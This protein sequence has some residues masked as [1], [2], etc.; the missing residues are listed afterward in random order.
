MVFGFIYGD[1]MYNKEF[2][3]RVYSG[4]V[5]PWLQDDFARFMIDSVRDYL[6][7]EK[8]IMLDYGCGNGAVAAY[9]R[10]S[11]A[12]VDTAEIADDMVALLRSTYSGTNVYSVNTPSDIP[13]KYYYDNV[14]CLNVFHHISPEY[15]DVFLD[16][17]HTLIKPGGRLIISG[18]DDSDYY[19]NQN[20]NV[21]LATQ[22]TS[23][24]ITSLVR[25]FVLSQWS[26]IDNTVRKFKYAGFEERSM[27]FY[28][29]VAK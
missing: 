28:C 18:W 26:L 9:F 6:K 1:G 17:L 22:C 11:G 5:K 21:A 24:T 29:L 20:D 23:W 27:R 7:P 10:N 2:W 15:W 16:Q 13:H 14:L 4:R 8:S 25:H 3:N 12:I 19:L